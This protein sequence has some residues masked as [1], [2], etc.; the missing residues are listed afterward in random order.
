MKKIVLGLM[1]LV[2]G[3]ML[4]AGCTQ[5][6]GGGEGGESSSEAV[7]Y[8]VDGTLDLIGEAIWGENYDSAEFI[9][10][11]AYNPGWRAFKYACTV[12]QDADGNP[13]A[14]ATDNVESVLVPFQTSFIGFVNTAVGEGFLTA[15]EGYPAFVQD[16]FA[17]DDPAAEGCYLTPDEG[18]V[19]YACNYV[20][21]AK[22]YVQFSATEYSPEA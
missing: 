17:A 2:I 19:V 16:Y 15:V 3:S 10:D 22:M 11:D 7:V 5:K 20:Y 14:D 1:P 6:Q 21:N 8:T 18:V 13:Y 4:L 9:E 12:L